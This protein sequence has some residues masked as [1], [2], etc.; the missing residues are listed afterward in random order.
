MSY[1]VLLPCMLIVYWWAQ[2]N[3]LSGGYFATVSLLLTVIISHSPWLSPGVDTLVALCATMCC[4]SVALW[5]INREFDRAIEA[6]Q[7]TLPRA[8][9]TT[10][11]C[12]TSNHD[13][14]V[15]TGDFSVPVQLINDQDLPGLNRYLQGLS[16]DARQG[17]YASI[18]YSKLSATALRQLLTEDRN[19]LDLNIFYGHTKVCEAKQQGLV[20]GVMP[21]EEAA[22]ALAI[23]F[24]HF[25][26]AQRLKADDPESLCGLIITKGCVALK[27]TQIEASLKDLLAI[28]PLHMHGVLSA[29]R[30]LIKSTEQANRF[31]EL[32]HTA[33]NHELTTSI[34]GFVA[35]IECGG[36]ATQARVDSTVVADLYRQLRVYRQQH[37]QLGMWQQ[38][39]CNN[40]IAFTFERIGD[41]DEADRRLTELQGQASPYPWQ[42]SSWSEGQLATVQF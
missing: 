2:K 25:R 40:V 20:P 11:F 39:I 1:L 3:E 4:M 21:G 14:A 38:A 24:K 37:H 36:L 13:F 19:H 16:A 31:V 42:R 12:S 7:I 28:D 41:V 34:A 5:Y 6:G 32:V 10:L 35:H 9:A 17:M 15:D 22:A 26:I 23:A 33:S 18:D 8:K 29:A 27:D 30:F